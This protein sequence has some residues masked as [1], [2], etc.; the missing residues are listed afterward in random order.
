[1]YNLELFGGAVH[2]DLGF[3]LSWGAFPLLTAY[4]AEAQTLTWA[5]I[6]AAG[7]ATALS[8]AQRALSTPARFLRRQVDEVQGELRRVDGE[9]VAIDR[10]LLLAPLERALRALTWSVVLGATALATARLA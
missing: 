4:V 2:S 8:L 1:A 5:P 10:D 3:A 7:G 6:L 9:V